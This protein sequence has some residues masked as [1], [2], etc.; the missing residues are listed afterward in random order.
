MI[1]D[2]LVGPIEANAAAEQLPA[3]ATPEIRPGDIPGQQRLR[4]GLRQHCLDPRASLAI[5]LRGVNDFS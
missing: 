4:S 3:V 5:L 1:L 2:P